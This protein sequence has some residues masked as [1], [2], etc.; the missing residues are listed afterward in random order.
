M[1]CN[2]KR[3]YLYI[4]I[5]SV[6]IILFSYFLVENS[7]R[8]TFYEHYNGVQISYFDSSSEISDRYY[9]RE[10]HLFDISN[11]LFLIKPDSDFCYTISNSGKIKAVFI[12]TSYFSNVETRSAM[13]RA[14]SNEDLNKLGVRRIFLLGITVDNKYVNQNAIRD[15]ARRYGDLV[16]GNFQEAYRNLTYK[17]IMGLMWVNRYCENAQFV[18][19]MDDDIV[20]NLLKLLDLLRNMDFKEEF[21]SGYVLKDLQVK[22]VR[23]NKWYVTKEEY[24]SE[25]YPPFVSGWLYI[26]TVTVSKKLE[27]L[28]S[29]EK[30]FWIDDVFVTGILAKKI[31]IKMYNIK[32]YYTDHPQYFQCCLN[33]YKNNKLDCDIIIGPNGGRTNLFYE[34]NSV[35]SA[36]FNGSCNARLY[37]INESCST[38]TKKNY[39]GR[40]N[41]IVSSYNLVG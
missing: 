24:S 36:C 29:G 31:N 39:L 35:F 40:G 25:I 21:I 16:Q 12:V 19:K 23:A 20:V 37:K 28:A 1:L 6:L 4:F 11:F 14:F 3:V 8:K 41:P 5:C 17:H 18:I 22:R 13:R 38:S 27:N 30:Y 15:E 2:L 32:E 33:D 10:K 34:F 7:F 9:P 26:T